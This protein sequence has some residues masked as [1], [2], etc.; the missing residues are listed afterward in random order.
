M[1]DSPR[2]ITLATDF[3]H[4]W[5]TLGEV[6]KNNVQ[7]PQAEALR[8]QPRDFMHYLFVEDCPLIE[9]VD[10]RTAFANPYTRKFYGADSQQM[11]RYR[12]AS[13]IEQEIVPNQKISLVQTTNRGGILT[14]P[15]ILAMNRGPILRGVWMLERILGERLPEP[16]PNVGTVPPAPPGQKLSF[17][18]RFEQHRS[19]AA[20][21]VCHNKIDPL[22]FA[23]ERYKGSTYQDGAQVDTAGQLPSGEK[24]K[25]FPELKRILV[26]S[27]KER[28]IR[29][30]V[31]R[32]LT[33]AV[34]RKLELYD[35]PA[36][37]AMTEKL[38]KS[39]G[40]YRDLIFEIATSLPFR[41]T[42]VDQE[43]LSRRTGQ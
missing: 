31:E 22:G 7:V 29:N 9:L 23:L 3:A 19:K 26:T 17:R 6:E 14:M 43:S 28:V 30:I 41:Q 20:C 5:L 4:Q 2:S 15:G 34:C 21:A 39:N 24:F 13:G 33:Y 38:L 8:S 27:Q 18:Q 40:T 36:V 11:K 1:I 32:A 10:S 25:D 37:D 16:P 42:M 12:K 35:R